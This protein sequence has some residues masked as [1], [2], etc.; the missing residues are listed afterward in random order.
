[1]PGRL[2][3]RLAVVTGGAR[4]IG[5]SIAEAFVAEGASVVVV[6]QLTEQGESLARSLGAGA[7]F[8]AGDVTQAATWERLIEGLDAELD[9]LVNNAGG[10]RHPERLHE[11]ELD[12]WRDELDRNLTSTFLGMRAAIP[13]MIA[14]GGGSIVNMASISGSIGQDDAPA[15]QAAK[16]GVRLLTKNA[17]VTYGPHNIRVN[18]ICPG[19]ID[20]EAVRQEDPDRIAPF[21]AR[22][23]MGRQGTPDE[24]ARAAVFL[25]S[26]DSRFV[27]GVDLFVDGGYTS[28]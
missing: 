6:D 14:R 4:G 18:A 20:T 28:R 13:A 1:M 10:M 17:A 12:A 26:D 16:A 3:H 5:A 22:T 21:L 11:I 19:A 24:V 2:E 9:V 8:V 23:P 7:R 25:A 15:Y 27:T